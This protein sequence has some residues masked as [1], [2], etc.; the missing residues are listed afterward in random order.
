MWN[1]FKKVDVGGACKL[2][3]VVVKTFGNTTNL[4]QHFKRKHPGINTSISNSKYTKSITTATAVE[5]DED[6]ALFVQ[7]VVSFMI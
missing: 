4:K 2:C 7:S 1:Y 6:D 3:S 5:D